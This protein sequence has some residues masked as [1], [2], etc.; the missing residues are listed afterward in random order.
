[1]ASVTLIESN[2]VGRFANG[3]KIRK[4][5]VAAYCRVSTDSDEQKKSYDSQLAY[6]TN[7]IQKNPE[8]EFVGIYADEAITGTSVTKRKSFQKLI[9]DCTSG[10]IDVVMTKSISRFARNTLDT[11]TYVRLLK[12]HN[13]DV[14]F[15]DENIHTI[16]MEGEMV[17]T[18]LSS[19]YQQEVENISANVKKG[20]KM[21]AMRGETTA[22]TGCFG[23][24]Y[25][26]ETQAI[27]INEDEAKFVRLIYDKYIE[28]CGCRMIADMLTDMNVITR[29]GNTRWHENTVMDILKSE[30]YIGDILVG[31]TF[32][33]D[34]ISKRRLTNYG[35]K[36]QI[37]ISDHHEPIISKEK[38]NL[39]QE[40]RRSKLSSKLNCKSKDPVERT[41][42]YVSKYAFS[43]KVICGCCGS[44][45]IRRSQDG[46]QNTR[47]RVWICK[48]QKSKGKSNCPHSK[49]ISEN[50]L[51]HIFLASYKEIFEYRPELIETFFDNIE[52]AFETS[53]TSNTIMRTKEKLADIR[54]KKS[55]LIDTQLNGLIDEDDYKTKYN[56]LL[57]QE[58]EQ[59]AR[60]KHLLNETEAASDL[61]ERIKSFREYLK[62]GIEIN[63]FDRKLFET[64]VDH[65]EVGGY[66]EDGKYDNNRIAIIYSPSISTKTRR[67]DSGS[68]EI[69][70]LSIHEPHFEF[71]DTPTGVKKKLIDDYNLSIRMAK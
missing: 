5:R 38:Y 4:Q 21:K 65:I 8:W 10:L 41:S 7:E 49:V 9:D 59:N 26:K 70:N 57:V 45:Y 23:Y 54:T 22:F 16:S 31:K 61:G 34:P 67:T 44:I 39:V 58:N 2:N 17:L 53:S 29:R 27:T 43:G 63:E 64:L 56:Q 37:Y 20:I 50:A 51:E 32:T 35:E 42:R 18:V 46:E 11:L 62:K 6:Y 48:T 19:V 1:M 68:I 52:A 60:L 28:G 55:K 33:V 12:Q 66:N 25:D 13:V 40:I 30:K 14:F 3:V 69:M 24:D 47:K 36:D 15:E 71:L